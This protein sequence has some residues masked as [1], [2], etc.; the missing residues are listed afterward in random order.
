MAILQWGELSGQKQNKGGTN[1]QK[2]FLR[3]LEDAC[4][5][6]FRG[7]GCLYLLYPTT[8]LNLVSTRV[9]LCRVLTG[10]VTLYYYYYIPSTPFIYSEGSGGGTAERK[11]SWYN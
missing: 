5:S 10:R 8:S 1:G 9:I 2:S 6:Q 4:C 3:R 7:C 11:L